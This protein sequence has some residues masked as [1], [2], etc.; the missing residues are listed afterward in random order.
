ME[1]LEGIKIFKYMTKSIATHLLILSDVEAAY[2]AGLVD[3]DGS[4]FII[5]VRKKNRKKEFTGSVGYI[6]TIRVTNTHRFMIELCDKYGG[7]WQDQDFTT[8]WKQVYRWILSTNLCKWYLPLIF[9]YLNIKRKQGEVMMKALSECKGSGHSVDHEK[10][11][12]YRKQLQKLN[13]V[14]KRKGR[15]P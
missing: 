3:G 15:L 4:M 12:L 8:D 13:R 2:L 5:K 11:E 9:P 14:G 7:F 1:T 6:P 10:M